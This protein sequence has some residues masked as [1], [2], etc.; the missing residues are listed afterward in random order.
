MQILLTPA[1]SEE[2]FL[3]SLCNGLSYFNSYGLEVKVAELDYQNAKKNL[4]SPCYEDVL[5]Q[6]L[7]DGGKMKVVDFEF[8]GEYNRTITLSDV[9]E[10]VQKT[11][12]EFLIDM[13]EGN[14]DA[15]TA[16]CILQT[17][18]FEDILFG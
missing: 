6:V 9:H 2:F 8:D 10:R 18:F 11:P 1:E 17:V 14:D 15:E 13:K 7:R 16:D 5:M 12:A 4:E 3:N